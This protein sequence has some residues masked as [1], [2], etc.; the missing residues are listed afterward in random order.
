LAATLRHDA[1]LFDLD[2]TLV[3]SSADIVASVNAAR[4]ALGRGA[5]PAD[6]VRRAIGDGVEMLI[7]RLF[8]PEETARAA[9]VY[10]A[11]HA[12]HLLDA[13]R[14]YPGVPEMLEALARAGGRLAVVTNKPL[15]YTRVILER[16]GL[17]RRLGAV[18]G[19]DGPAGRKPAPGPFEEALVR[20][21]ARREGAVVVGDGRN[22]VLG[23]RA[24][25]LAVVGVLYG[26][27]SPEE[28]RALG[29][30]R[31]VASVEELRDYLTCRR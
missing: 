11:H 20:L 15:G 7:A 17:D 9:A 27:G 25:R 19:G 4:A 2:G 10:R 18:I 8:P 5:V 14:P 6:E 24:A 22:D 28:M 26:I 13:T 21:G 16:L 3:D 1:I 12:E 23:A 29:P 31:A 30:D